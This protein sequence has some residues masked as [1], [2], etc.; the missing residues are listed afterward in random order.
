MFEKI[1]FLK[2]IQMRVLL[3]AILLFGLLKADAQVNHLVI[4]QV[5]GGGGNTGASYKNDFVELFNPTGATV[6]LASYSIQYASAAGT[7]W[8]SVNL[9]GS[10]AA[11]KYYLIQVQGGATGAA[12]PTPDLSSILFNIAV[13]SGKV[14][15]C[16]STTV[17]SGANPTSSS[18][19]DLFGWG[20]TATSFETAV[21]PI[22]TNTTSA[23]RQNGGCTD[24]GNNSTDF[25][26]GTVNPRNSSTAANYCAPSALTM[27]SIASPQA[28][29]ITFS[30][31]VNSVDAGGTL[32]N[33][34]SNTT[35]TLTTN[36]NAGTLSGT[37]TGTITAGS[38]SVTITG[39]SLSGSGTAVTIT[40]ST[41][42]NTLT[43]VTSN[44]FDVSAP[45]GV[46]QTITF[47]TLSGMTYGDA[48]LTLGATAS[49][50][51]TVSYSSSNTAVVS[52]SGNTLTV[53]GAG[54][55]NVT[56]S[57]AGNG[58]YNPAPNVV[59]SITIS[60]KT[61]T[62]A[63][64]AA[65]NKAYNGNAT[66]VITGTLS[67]VVG[68]DDVA[69]N[70][71]GTFADVNVADGIAV[72]AAC[73]LTG[74]T[75]GNYTL[76]QPTGLSANITAANA[77]ITF[78]AIPTY[79]TA[80]SSFTLNATASSGAT[81]SYTSSNTSVATVT[82]NVVTIVAAGTS[83][84][85]ASAGA[86][87]NFNAPSSV[88][89]TLTVTSA[90]MAFDFFG[91]NNV[92]T[93]NP[94]YVLPG[95]LP[96]S[97]QP[98]TRGA[99]AASS[100][101]ANS[102]RTVGFQNNGIATTNTDYF[103][104]TMTANPGLGLNLT[105]I[106]ARYAGTATY[107]NVSPG[108]SV[109][110]AY[111]LDGTNYT[112]ISSPTLLYSA[113]TV[114]SFTQPQIDLSGISA[115]QNIQPGT[116]VSFR[117]YASGQT[118]TGGWGFISTA[119]GLHGLVIGGTTFAVPCA[120]YADADGDGYGNP[121]VTQNATCG[122]T[123][124]GYVELNNSDCNDNAAGVHPGA[125]EL[126]CNSIDDNCN[127]T[128]DENFVTGCNDPLA[129]NYS[130]AA[131]C[132]TGCDYTAQTFYLDADNDTYGTNSTTETGCA[133]SAGYVLTG[134][135][136]NDNN[137][138]VNPGATEVLCNGIDDNCNAT[139]D[140]G[141]VSGCMDPNA[142]N[143]NA[144]ANCS[145]TC[146]YTNFTAGNILVMKLGTGAA[147]LSS[148]GTPVFVEERSSTALV[149]TITIPTTGANRMV[150]NGS[151][152]AEGQ[153]TRTQDGSA[154]VFAG[155][156]AAAG[157][158]SINGTAS[159]TVARVISTL[160]LN[161][162]TFAR[163][164]SSST[165]FS[166]QNFRSA[167]ANGTDFWG[168][169]GAGGVNYFGTG[170]AGSVSTTSN[171]NRVVAVQNGQLYI[172]TG[173]GTAGVYAVGTG[174]PT[175]TGTTSTIV[176]ATGTG[177]SPYAFQFSADGNT[178]YVADDRTTTAGGIQKWTKS[179]GVWSL[180]YT[181]SVGSAT[182]ARGLAVDF[183]AG[184]QP[185]IYAVITNAAGTGVVYLND[186]GT[187][188]P[189]V[190]TLATATTA[191]NT[192]Y[193]SLA[194]APCNSTNWY[195][196][197][198][199]D[200]YG[201]LNTTLSYCTQP[202]GY[203]SNSTDCDDAVAASNPAASEICDGL[204]NDCNGT[205]DNGLTFVNYYNDGDGDTYG[206]GTATNACQSPGASYV[207]NN[208]DC[209]DAVA[210]VNPGASE[211]CDGVDNNCAGGIDN[212]L[213]FVNY[214]NDV[215]GDTFGAGSAINACQ[216]P[217]AAYVLNNSDCDDSNN[218]VNPNGIEVCGGTDENCDGQFNEGLTFYNYYQ[219]LDGDGYG[220]TVL[221]GNNCFLPS[222]AGYPGNSDDCDDT[223]ASANPMG[224]DICNNGIDEDCSGADCVS[225]LTAAINVNNIGQFGTGIQASYTV[226]LATG[227]NTIESP[228]IG[229][230]KWFK[231]TATNNAVRVSIT[232]SSLVADDN[233]ISLY[234]EPT[235]TGTQLIPLVAENDVHVGTQGAAADAG[236]EILY[237][238]GLV[239]GNV[240]YICVRNNNGAAGTVS[241]VVS[242]LKASA[243]DIM[244]YTTASCH[245]LQVI[246]EIVMIVMI[247]M[248]RQILWE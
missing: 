213:T 166:A 78:N 26:T 146:N 27:G 77:T 184:A 193:R 212:G 94:S 145:A 151:S 63:G 100:A 19:V 129:C 66:A 242:Y 228:G 198:D 165:L 70:G 79:S 124:T 85:T 87:T 148:S 240:Y 105:S 50:G 38:S 44:T 169:G 152:A 98:I 9:T 6:S 88:T 97:S 226:N 45:V 64:A 160:G 161:A 112:L 196:D 41:A 7:T 109:Q 24:A 36:G 125:T 208:T 117:F 232:G 17:L 34:L 135:D 189:T 167:T 121:S 25:T 53:V 16:N 108:V 147:A 186:N 33:V 104:F 194:F 37:T 107:Y 154:V 84:I 217:G 191:S 227:T 136:C 2:S 91:M 12:L 82:G 204:D 89:Q 241:M 224:I 190:N 246:Q 223:N 131:T 5:Y 1:S 162:G 142:T 137:V 157:T 57:Q 155:Y 149:Q 48:P 128:V 150:V 67:G 176:F 182:G 201:N 156:D 216:S 18:I 238:D 69:L 144:S 42:G 10:I 126:A 21:G 185:R 111:S 209:N 168:V 119:S 215:D 40:A 60:P 199:G 71:L 140:E 72:T 4:S 247:P 103:Q 132:A 8:N 163:Q 47:N 171:N 83:V 86:A 245:L 68:S 93:A 62:I 222:F 139:V 133:P 229:L 74:T 179:A 22:H 181:I 14:A 102:F 13:G 43:S 237:Y 95:M 214:Y 96:A 58:S 178:C 243:S 200:G 211:V 188:T 73:T 106:D 30:V 101:A 80:N 143:Y 3:T 134:G 175:A 158:P 46:D 29:G 233:D 236:S 230:D 153:M 173:S 61:L 221:I 56:A 138:A 180:A 114:T 52:I 248:H 197:A 99:G 244:P 203:V 116:T 183:Y 192:A 234:N 195:A 55:A 174:T 219:D 20:A 110:Y 51:L 225:G 75:A 202:Y 54:T 123:V 239:S 130:A 59:Q 231:F 115:L 118:T 31:V 207:T 92:A 28:Q 76:T 120:F 177:S 205:A 218:A 81:V 11:G 35:V 206:A 39:V 122:S 23:L 65:Q 220:S 235:T 90:L 15:L 127:G 159:A 32:K 187:A 170:T 113:T 164:S 172:S 210:S 141:S 49:S